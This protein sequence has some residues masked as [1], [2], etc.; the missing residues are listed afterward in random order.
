MS[1]PAPKKGKIVYAQQGEK[2]HSSQF[3]LTLNSN[4]ADEKWG[5]KIQ[6][7][8][9][10]WYNNIEE[11]LVA[12]DPDKVDEITSPTAAVESGDKF[13]RCHAHLYFEIKHRTWVQINSEKTRAF[14]KN[15]L[16]R[17][18]YFNVRHVPS[19]QSA[20]ENYLA[21]QMGKNKAKK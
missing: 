16:D 10:S 6:E 11:Y 3:F 1:K 13:H 17:N 7:A 8:L 15:F 21:K 4:S 12:A 14:F 5:P 9:E 20:I 2:K 19:Y 18:A